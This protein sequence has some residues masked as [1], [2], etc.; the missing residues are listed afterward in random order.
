LAATFLNLQ[1][2]GTLGSATHI[3]AFKATTAHPNARAA[4]REPRVASR[5]PLSLFYLDHLV[6][7]HVLK[8]LTHP[9]R[10]LDFDPHRIGG[11]A[12]AKMYSGV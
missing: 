5:E 3:E 10:P 6:C 4:D 2:S 9:G 12:E 7:L 11:R 8:R 1:H